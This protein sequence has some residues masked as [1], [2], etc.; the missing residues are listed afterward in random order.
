MEGAEGRPMKS[1][2]KKVSCLDGY[3]CVLVFISFVPCEDALNYQD[4]HFAKPDFV[5]DRIKK[6]HASS[7]LLV[8]STTT[9]ITM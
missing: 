2:L 6:Y 8:Y 4:Y 5:E 3:L 7:K 1:L 9:L